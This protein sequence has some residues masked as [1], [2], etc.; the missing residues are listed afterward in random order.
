M[1]VAS[2]TSRRWPEPVAAEAVLIA[3][4]PAA[5]ADEPQWRLAAL[6]P[7]AGS[8]GMVGFA[9]LSGSVTFLVLSGVLV[10]VGCGVPLLNQRQRSHWQARREAARR[11]R[12]LRYLEQTEARLTRAQLAQQ[13][14]AHALYPPWPAIRDAVR[15]GHHWQRRPGD[16]DFGVVRVG[17]G[18]VPSV[19]P[20]TAEVESP[21]A[22]TGDELVAGASG[23]AARYSTVDDMPVTVDV[24]RGCIVLQ[25]CP[26]REGLARRT[27]VHVLAQI[28]L[29]H[30]P[31][32][33]KV[34]LSYPSAA[35]ADY[36]WCAHAPHVS[37]VHGGRADLLPAP[38]HDSDT[39][40]DLPLASAFPCHVAV[41]DRLGGS[42]TRS[43]GG[44]GAGTNADRRPGLV[45][46]SE[47]E[48]STSAQAQPRRSGALLVVPAR[49][50]VPEGTSTVMR[51]DPEGCLWVREGRPDAPSVLVARPETVSPAEAAAVCGVLPRRGAA[52][53]RTTQS[54]PPPELPALL[55]QVSALRRLAVPF[56]QYEDGSV[57]ILN[58]TEPAEGGAGPHGLLVGA[59]GSGKSELLRTL[60][61]GLAATQ[62]ADE[63][64]MVL[65]DY[66][67]GTAFAALESLPHVAG[68]VT[69]L[70]D[71][72]GLIERMQAALVGELRRRQQLL[73]D[74]GVS[75]VV[76]YARLPARPDGALPSL[77]LVVD[78]FAELLAARPELVDLF[79]RVGR[80]GRGL[81]V[82]LL[83][84]AQR[85]DEGR[86]RALEPHLRF[87]LCLRTFTAAES[88]AVVGS[89]A[90][91]ELPA[92]PG[93]GLFC[94]D[95][96]IRRFRA[97]LAGQ[98]APAACSSAWPRATVHGPAA[99]APIVQAR[100]GQTPAVDTADV[101]AQRLAPNDHPIILP[102]LP[103]SLTLDRLLAA[104]ATVSGEAPASAVSTL[105]AGGAGLAAPVG[106]LDL[107]AEH[108]QRTFCINFGGREGH[109]A[110]VGG[111]GS[112][113]TTLL[114]TLVAG[115]ALTS[116]PG[117]VGVFLLDT[118]GALAD[119]IE[120][121][122]VADVASLDDPERV[123]AV[124]DELVSLC[125][126]RTS[127]WRARGISDMAHYTRAGPRAPGDR[128]GRVVLAIDDVGRLRVRLPG[129]ESQLADLAARGTRAGIHLVVTAAKWADLR[130]GLRECIARRLE[131]ALTEPAESE[132]PRH[133]ALQLHREALPGRA[134][135]A[136]GRQLQVALPYLSKPAQDGL[137]DWSA[138]IA[139]ARSRHPNSAGWH[140]PLTLLPHSLALPPAE[141]STGGLF[142]GVRAPDLRPVRVELS[143]EA[144]HLL[145]LGDARSG[146]SSLLGA[147]LVQIRRL[148]KDAPTRAWVVDPRASLGAALAAAGADASNGVGAVTVAGAGTEVAYARTASEVQALATSLASVLTK[149]ASLAAA[150]PKRS[151]QELLGAELSGAESSGAELS[152][153]TAASRQTLHVLVIDDHDLVR[154]HAAGALADLAHHLPYGT[155]NGL[156][157]IL[158]RRVTGYSRAAY[159]PLVCALRELGAPGVL[160]SGDPIEGPVLHG[161]RAERRP[162][163]RGLLLR[164]DGAQVS[165]QVAAFPVPDLGPTV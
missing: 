3:A 117:D 106:L 93:V 95:G 104:P 131:F 68:F 11:R 29:M 18:R 62:S 76:D 100:A 153:A 147:I 19:S 31:A 69:N 78:E 98:A 130:G 121:P 87:R 126:L 32:D 138:V 28:L 84:A 122:H 35:A 114:R 75:C 154:G 65:I 47:A 148:S 118:T 74:A 30:S 146:R 59:T 66:K 15:R 12:Y 8:L 46:E 6:L 9:L 13:K 4:P 26:G 14:H 157:L 150:T 53:G 113:R 123:A 39:H 22:D 48:G 33:L 132:L 45:G 5:A 127:W 44:A 51:L 163:G 110:A 111:A 145:V 55:K 120:L 60:V 79:V 40:D 71:A 94:V 102:P 124:L 103:R 105:R 119:T 21:E 155:E 143:N 135:L 91:Y 116:D 141:P 61:C 108:A 89:T 165:V 159:D 52:T 129:V 133:N 67:G 23:L 88:H 77:L 162:P 151:V 80:I 49:A 63:L 134:C 27:A 82:H 107:P 17:T 57:A 36:A 64:R 160:L 43:D 1:P 139:L 58:L 38:R 25:A 112:G 92:E 41:V 90:A 81:G 101:E 137:P 50:A 42:V 115:L 7:A 34:T 140:R 85:L 109:T 149:S 2:P 83:L 97:S 16:P 142:V 86:L 152:G 20:V 125:E 128:F 54:M 56:G 24:V 37:D 72:D 73:R 164:A 99:L 136:D 10:L 144:S 161:V 156:R 70:L 158:V 96:R